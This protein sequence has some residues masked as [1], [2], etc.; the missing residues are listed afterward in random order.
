MAWGGHSVLDYTHAY[1][2]A[3]LCVCV[4]IY[5]HAYSNAI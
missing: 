4:Y 2:C 5:T 1:M 3:T